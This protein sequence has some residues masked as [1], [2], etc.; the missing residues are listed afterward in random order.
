MRVSGGFEGEGGDPDGA[1]DVLAAA[2]LLCRQT[3]SS[4]LG[5]SAL[6]PSPSLCSSP[7]FS[8]L[9]LWLLICSFEVTP[10]L[11]ICVPV[12]LLPLCPCCVGGTVR[13]QKPPFNWKMQVQDPV[14]AKIHPA[15]VS[16]RK[17]LRG[18]QLKGCDSATDP[19]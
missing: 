18:S 11:M 6:L 3:G 10:A 8:L 19:D 4:E 5:L 14:R 9:L 15:V 16:L 1:T 13:R 12:C 7:L 17:R 2:A